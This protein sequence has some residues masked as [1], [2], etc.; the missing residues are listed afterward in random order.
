[1]KAL[2]RS[3]A[4]RNSSDVM[5]P[6]STSRSRNA[7]TAA[8]DATIPPSAGSRGSSA[9]MLD[10]LPPRRTTGSRLV[11]SAET[12]ALPCRG[13]LDI[14]VAAREVGAVL[15][16][17]DMVAMYVRDWPSALAWY[18][19][20]LGFVGA[21]VEEDH[22]FAVLALPAGGPVL[23]LVGDESREPGH[24]NR[25][26]PNIAVDD[27]DATLADLAARGVRIMDV[28]DDLDDGYRLARLADPE[29]NELNV[30]TTVARGPA[31][32]T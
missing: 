22:H 28:V 25:C 26:V 32:P 8:V 31:S 13:V 19:D 15:Q 21:Y 1:M 16:R 9:D 14:V 10:S 5:M 17:I 24:Q 2:C 4:S 30:Y 12:G 27:F 23:H 18:Q 3:S 11:Q 29:G 20:K 6:F 7:S